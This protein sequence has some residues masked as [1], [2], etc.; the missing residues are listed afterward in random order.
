MP[1]IHVARDGAKL[2]EFTLEQI[3]A[4]LTA[5]Q[6]R[7]TDLGWQTGMA[8]WRPL[9]EMVPAATPP[10][11]PVPPSLPLAAAATA[12]PGA[13]LP[14]EHRSQLGFLRAFFDTVSL[15]VTKPGD[16]FTLMRP[17]GGLGDPLLFALIGGCAASIVSLALQFG[18]QSVPG[19]GSNRELFAAFGVAPWVFFILGAVFTPIMLAIGLFIG[20]GILHLCL[21]LVGGANRSFETTFR[22]VCFS[23]GT[24]NLFSMVPVCGGL[25]AIGF[26]IALECI[27]ISRAHQTTTGKALIAIFLP[28]MVCCGL[29]IV[30]VIVLSGSGAFSEMLN[31]HH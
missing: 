1:M 23:S 18:L 20:S 14:W 28:L 16:A 13:G 21:M 9:S 26:N 11:E 8:E 2:G 25:I 31:R 24:A 3:R 12:A 4:G 10:G 6:F 15:L 5:G 22:V 30:L 29:M 19:L 17:E 7:L 27:G